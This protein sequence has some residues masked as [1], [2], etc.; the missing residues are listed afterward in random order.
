MQKYK[1]AMKEEEATTKINKIVLVNWK[2]LIKMDGD[3]RQY[4]DAFLKDDC[5][6]A[7]EEAINNFGVEH[8]IC[9]QTLTDYVIGALCEKFYSRA[10][11]GGWPYY[12]LEDDKDDKDEIDDEDGDS[13]EDEDGDSD[14]SDE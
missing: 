1:R 13:S 10:E 11:D 6:F 3:T 8:G 9:L 4:C 2:L 12:P 7:V 5:V 14:S